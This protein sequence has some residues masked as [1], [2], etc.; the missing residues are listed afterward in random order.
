[1]EPA[2]GLNCRFAVKRGTDH[3]K[4]RFEHRYNRFEDDQVIVSH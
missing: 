3:S 4:S 1:M 2:L